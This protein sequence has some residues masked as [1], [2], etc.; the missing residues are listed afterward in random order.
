V[1]G[2]QQ[3]IILWDPTVHDIAIE[4]STISAAEDVAVRYESPGAFGILLAGV[5]STDSGSGKGFGSSLGPA[6]P[7]VT[8][9]NSTLH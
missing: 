7:G 5:T 9:V 2:T 3:A 1:S 8:F 4:D 6:P